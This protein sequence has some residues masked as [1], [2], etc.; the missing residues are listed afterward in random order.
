[1]A[2]FGRTDSTLGCFGVIFLLTCSLRVLVS[3]VNVDI[4][5]SLRV[6]NPDE[7]KA[8]G[9]SFHRAVDPLPQAEPGK[10][11]SAARSVLPSAP[12]ETP[13]PP[14][15]PAL[16]P[17][18]PPVAPALPPPP[19]TL[20][21]SAAT[22]EWIE[23]TYMEKIP[24]K[25][26]CGGDISEHLPLFRALCSDA[27]NVASCAELGV[28]RAYATWAFVAAAAERY[29]AGAPPLRVRLYDLV[30]RAE[31]TELMARLRAECPALDVRFTEG[32]DLAMPIEPSDV[33]LLDTWHTFKQ[34]R[35]ELKVLPR[36]VSRA[37]ILHD[38]RTFRNRDEKI[39]GRGGLG[40][41]PE[42]F[43]GVENQVGLQPAVA[44]FLRENS[45]WLQLE[46]RTNCNGI[47]I[48]APR[49]VVGYCPK[50]RG[51]ACLT[52]RE[53]QR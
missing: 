15:M 29:R 25:K 16:P 7:S 49:A 27:S 36:D 44:M 11:D 48:L 37:I 41:V 21:C 32:D 35:Q 34:L 19:L 12:A 20:T 26:I 43:A 8:G 46:E 1:M 53:V 45:D 42:R 18:A 22:L 52:D 40:I 50:A 6:R 3:F 39:G 28:R 23:R 31:V 4:N 38:T 30:E 24:T 9:L 33:M 5:I 17:P 47:T 51:V 13:V 2:R 14:A 10:F